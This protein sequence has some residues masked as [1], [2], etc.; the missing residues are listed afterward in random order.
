MVSTTV[1]L[2]K[3]NLL[4][5]PVPAEFTLNLALYPLQVCG[6]SKNASLAMKYLLSDARVTSSMLISELVYKA[7]GKY[8]FS[9]VRFWIKLACL[10]TNNKK[11]PEPDTCVVLQ[12]NWNCS[13]PPC[14]AGKYH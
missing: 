13:A 4:L 12:D 6:W 14:K 1:N 2:K 3:L 9:A 10:C 5:V 7:A 8:H 11:K